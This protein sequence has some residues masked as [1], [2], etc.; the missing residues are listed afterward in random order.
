M[1]WGT[2][3]RCKYVWG[4]CE[5]RLKELALLTPTKRQPRRH[6]GTAQNHLQG[7][8]GHDRAKL[9]SAVAGEAAVAANCSVGD[10]SWTSEAASSVGGGAALAQAA[11]GCWSS[12]RALESGWDTATAD[13]THW[14]WWEPCFK[15]PTDPPIPPRI[16]WSAGQ[17]PGASIETTKVHFCQQALSSQV[18]GLLTSRSYSSISD[19]QQL[20]WPAQVIREGCY[21]SLSNTH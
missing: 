20:Y 17:L 19:V 16:R 5:L 9:F 1:K 8:Y 7:S 3:Q 2:P 18:H 21:N 15:R 14:H 6:L 11:W 4:T 10:P 13:L 12:I